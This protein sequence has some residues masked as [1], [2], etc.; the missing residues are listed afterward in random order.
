VYVI[1]EEKKVK[2]NVKVKMEARTMLRMS[3]D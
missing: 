2:V 3:M 1:L